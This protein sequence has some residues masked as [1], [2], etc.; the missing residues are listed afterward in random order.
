M[1]RSSAASFARRTL[2]PADLIV[3]PPP[4]AP[5]C[6]PP[7]FA[8]TTHADGAFSRADVATETGTRSVSVFVSFVVTKRVRSN[9]VAAKCPPRARMIT[10]GRSRST[11]PRT[12]RSAASA[13]RSSARRSKSGAARTLVTPN[14]EPSSASTTIFA[15]ELVVSFSF[16]EI[17][18]DIRSSAAREFVAS[19]S[20]PESSRAS[21]RSNRPSRRWSSV[22][23]IVRSQHGFELRLR[24]GRAAVTQPPPVVPVEIAAV[25]LAHLARAAEP[26]LAPRVHAPDA[27]RARLDGKRILVDRAVASREMLAS[28]RARGRGRGPAAPEHASHRRDR[29]QRAH[30]HRRGRPRGPHA[31]PRRRAFCAAARR[32][33]F[34]NERLLGG[35]RRSETEERKRPEFMRC[36]F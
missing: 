14:L 4:S 28:A 5:L 2:L 6:L 10:H 11:P 17:L 36:R 26:E 7:A 24:H 25:M 27:R 20:S 9:A 33:S 12:S 8:R 23:Q 21:S 15:F 3:L 16:R 1:S 22:T 13:W 32:V 30:R 19:D 29:P 31:R 18:D 34:T 35:E